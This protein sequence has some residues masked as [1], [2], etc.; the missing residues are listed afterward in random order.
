LKE[1]KLKTCMSIYIRMEVTRT[2]KKQKRKLK[3]ENGHRVQSLWLMES[4][5]GTE[6]F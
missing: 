4:G 6:G 5:F 2:G 3:V 1:G